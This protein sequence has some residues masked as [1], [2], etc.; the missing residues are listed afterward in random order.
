MRR[1]SSAGLLAV[2]VLASCE[3]TEPPAAPD[4]APAAPATPV[5]WETFAA[6]RTQHL[7]ELGAP[8][9]ACVKNRDTEHAAF[10][11]C[12]DWHSAVHGVWALFAL[13]RLE[14]DA[15]WKAAATA[16][17]DYASIDGVRAALESEAL[18]AEVPYGYA[19]L[20]LLAVE[21]ERSTGANDLRSVAGLGAARL[22][23][24]LQGL[25][26]SAL[27]SGLRADDY[28]NVSWA[29]LNVWRYA[30]FT[31]DAKLQ[32]WAEAFAREHLLAD[33]PA[34]SLREEAYAVDNFFAPCLLR[35]HALE[36]MLPADEVRPWVEAF[37]G[38]DADLQP[39]TEIEKPHPGGLN[40]SRAWGLWSVYRV[41]GDTAWRDAY[42]AHVDTHLR[43]PRYWRDDYRSFSH[44]VPQFGVY[45][46]ALSYDSPRDPTRH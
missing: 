44:W 17:L 23:S 24:Y 19:W 3:K 40:F 26:P 7:A 6:A 9:E 41:T 14:G 27:A 39:L 35:A 34:C 36:N 37:I 42:V 15:K 21:R 11:G 43:Q 33:D 8:I 20:L 28:R 30:Q 22:Q 2:L 1:L 13:S 46:I 16:Q 10:H 25:A 5:T 18:P 45:A 29:L 38:R 12:Y 32:A 4:V 31:S